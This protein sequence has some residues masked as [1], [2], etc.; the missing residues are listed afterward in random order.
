MELVGIV[1]AFDFAIYFLASSDAK[2]ALLLSFVEMVDA[3]RM[4]WSSGL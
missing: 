1:M 4:R 2:V 3:M